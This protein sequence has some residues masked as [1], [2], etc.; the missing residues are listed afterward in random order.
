MIKI[1]IF[2]LI[3]LSA[4]VKIFARCD[5]P[6]IGKTGKI[7]AAQTFEIPSKPQSNETILQIEAAAE[8]SSWEIKDSES[9]VLTVF[10]D[11]QYN[12]DVMLFGGSEKFVYKIILGKLAAGKHQLK[13]VFNNAR[14]AKNIRA[15]KISRLN[16]SQLKNNAPEDAAAM[17]NAPFLYN[18]AD[19]IDKFSDI[20]LVTYY[21]ILPSSANDYKI[22]YTTIFTN[23]DGGTQTAALLARWGR[24]TDIEWVNEIEI[25]NG[26]SVGGIIQGINHETKTFAGKY[27]F[28]THPLIY[29]ASVNNNF[30]DSGC[31]PLRTAIAPI[32]ADLSKKSRETVMDEN[33][34]TYKLM[35]H[36]A[37]REGRIN[38]DKLDADIIA[39]L[40]DYVYAE[41]SG[42]PHN[43]AIAVEI[44]A[45]DGQKFSSDNGN[46]FLR[47]NRPG[48]VRIAVQMP[49]QMRGKFPAA[50]A[51]T[52]HA[53]SAEAQSECRNVNLIKLVRLNE[54]YALTE[55]KIS[56]PP[57]TVKAGER[58][59]FIISRK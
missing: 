9:A 8:K 5:E 17:A 22:R 20:P 48:F 10:V 15:A 3:L 54:N 43:A 44:A 46:K 59:E 31:S 58:A 25:K 6:I 27:V 55:L 32:R 7:I 53:A 14:S 28:G 57:Q 1:V 26:A 45:P 56:S 23:E 34:W 52:C 39:D 40:R 37:L 13:I 29:D 16:V 30:A 49:K 21:E 12:Q 18:R 36:E 50:L 38:P 19:T 42:E 24:A 11:E 2:T 47:V 35:A 4:T 33:A 41:I 51:V